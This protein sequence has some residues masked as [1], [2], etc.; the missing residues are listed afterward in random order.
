MSG[1]RTTIIVIVAA[2]F[3]P[4][5]ASAQDTDLPTTTKTATAAVATAQNAFE[6][7]DFER[8]VKLVRPWL[9]PR[10]ILDPK[11][12]LVARR[13][14]G[15]SMHVLGRIEEAKE[16]FA[17]LLLIDPQHKLDPFLVPPAVIQTFE[18]V[19]TSMRPTLNQILR[20]RG[21]QPIR[22]APPTGPPTLQL[23]E[24][25]PLA[26]ALLPGGIPQFAADETGWGVLWAVLQ[27]GFLTL[28]LVAFDQ[29]GRNNNN[30]FTT[31]TGLQYAGLVG[32]LGSWTASGIQGYNQLKGVRAR[33]LGDPL[34]VP[35]IVEPTTPA[36]SLDRKVEPGGRAGLSLGWNF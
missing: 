27:V 8:V 32:F 14:L 26:I 36:S 9:H 19:R 2:L 31:W 28:N 5:V 24:V 30:G 35:P 34:L 22:P 3:V 4:R 10:R 17:E 1:L 11:L 7:R 18:D 25:P 33:S 23:I 13:L 16:E 20:S 6:Y 12:A 21:I 15:V 29:A